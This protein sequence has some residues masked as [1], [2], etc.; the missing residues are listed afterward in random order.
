MTTESCIPIPVHIWRMLK[1]GGIVDV[2][3]KGRL[4]LFHLASFRITHY[5]SLITSQE[6]HAGG[7]FQQSLLE[8]D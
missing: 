6:K 5:P 4:D 7:L 3:R 2:K 1:T 8:S